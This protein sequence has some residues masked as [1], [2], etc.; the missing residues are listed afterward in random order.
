[1]IF[2][3]F[4]ALAQFERR[5]IQERTKAGLAAARARGRLGG[6]PK[7]T[8]VEAKV[9]LP[10]KLHADKSLEIDDICQTLR[11]NDFSEHLFP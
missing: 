1:L 10:K 6:A 2:N 9:V 8:A 4:S 11:I 7:V 5:L 3:I